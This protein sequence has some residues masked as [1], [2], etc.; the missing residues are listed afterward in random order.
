MGS[1]CET[2]RRRSIKG[3]NADYSCFTSRPEVAC[4]SV[5]TKAMFWDQTHC[6]ADHKEHVLYSG[7]KYFCELSE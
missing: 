1:L 7:G 5:C 3:L 4:I 6:A 2:G